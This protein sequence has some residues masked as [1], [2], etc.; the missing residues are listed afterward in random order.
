MYDGRINCRLP[1]SPVFPGLSLHGHCSIHKL[2]ILYV[3][4]LCY[5]SEGMCL[6]EDPVADM[7]SVDCLSVLLFVFSS[8]VLP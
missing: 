7:H 6:V 2:C 4:F 1:D 3:A 5:D 8:V